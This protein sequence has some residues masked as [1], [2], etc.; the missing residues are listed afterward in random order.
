[1]KKIAWSTHARK[2]LENIFNF[3][4]LKSPSIA[5][6]IHNSIL[7]EVV[8]LSQW[9]EIG[10][11]ERFIDNQKYKYPFRSLVIKNGLYKIIYFIANDY[12]VI[13]RIWSCRKNP[14][15]LTS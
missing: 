14:K 3:Y 12:I 4:L 5:A 6:K 13:S 15:S 9:P 10:Q 1:M 2:D 7:D 11:H 8:R